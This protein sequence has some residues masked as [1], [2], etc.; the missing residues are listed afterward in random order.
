[1]A[2]KLTVDNILEKTKKS[3]KFVPV[4]IGE[5]LINI[6]I[7][8][9]L[10]TQIMYFE[11]YEETNDYRSAFCFMVYS[12]LTDNKPLFEELKSFDITENEIEEL[13]DNELE[14]IGNVLIEKV[15]T[16]KKHFNSTDY[17][18]EDFFNA[19]SKE[20]EES[21]LTFSKLASSTGSL[22]SKLNSMG[23]TVALQSKFKPVNCY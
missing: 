13:S 2:E 15:D 8:Y 9:T 16:L 1:M 10:N 18:F 5:E 11:N 6:P 7:R 21:K 14:E 3:V 4:Y 19:I 20:K 12:M 23:K 22:I 17:F